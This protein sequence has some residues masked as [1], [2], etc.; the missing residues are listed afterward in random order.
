MYSPRPLFWTPL[1]A[2]IDSPREVDVRDVTDTTALVTWFLPVA[3]VDGVSVTYGPNDNPSDRNTVELSSSDTQ[4]HL[5]SLNPDT[6]YEVSL[7]AKRGEMTSV[8]VSE[9]FLTGKTRAMSQL[10]PYSLYSA[11]LFHQAPLLLWSKV[12][13]YIAGLGSIPISFEIP[14][15]FLI[16]LMKWRMYIEFHFNFNNRQFTQL[17]LNCN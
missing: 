11:L 9:N 2:E 12:L 6:E 17:G 10:A 16:S 3:V 13:H 4:Y 1:S 15:T 7:M 8:P 14:I 5:G